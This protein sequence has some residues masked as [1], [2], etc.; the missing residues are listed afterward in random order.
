MTDPMIADLRRELDKARDALEGCRTYLARHAEGNA[1][2]H[3][4]ERVMY[5]PL[6]AK[7]DTAVAGIDFALERTQ[8]NPEA[9][10]SRRQAAK[11]LEVFR[12]L[13][14]C[15]HGRHAQDPCEGGCNP[16][17]RPGQQIGYSRLAEPIFVPQ[18]A[19][20]HDPAAWRTPPAEPTP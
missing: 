16:I 18:W 7:V 5:S 12:D 20:K 15:Q 6:H 11:L 17:L 3:C 1:A 10:E 13:D 14:R 2:L 8:P 4:A 9:E 19:D